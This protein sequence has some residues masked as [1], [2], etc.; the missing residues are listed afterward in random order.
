LR[1]WEF[2]FTFVP[3]KNTIIMEILRIENEIKHIFAK[4]K[5]TDADIHLGKFL[6]NKWKRLTNWVEDTTPFLKHTI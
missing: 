5:I 1:E 6:I 3:I 4:D 2:C